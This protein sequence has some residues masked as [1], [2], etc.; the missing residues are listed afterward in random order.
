LKLRLLLEV[1]RKYGCRHAV[2]IALDSK[3]L[4]CRVIQETGLVSEPLIVVQLQ[5]FQVAREARLRW[6]IVHDDL[7]HVAFKPPGPIVNLLKS[8]WSSPYVHVPVSSF[9]E[10]FT[11]FNTCSKL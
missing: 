3:Y 1:S 8:A 10:A 11:T 7:E 5:R 4:R 2:A 6:Q 9:A